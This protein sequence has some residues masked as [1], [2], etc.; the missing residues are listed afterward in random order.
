MAILV[1]SVGDKLMLQYVLNNNL[2][3]RLY[4]N[5]YTPDKTSTISSFTEA[6]ESIPS[7]A[8]AAIPLIFSNWTISTDPVSHLTTA[9][10]PKQIFY[11]NGG[12]VVYGY[13][14]TNSSEV[15]YTER[16]TTAPFTLPT[17]PSGQQN[18]IAITLNIGFN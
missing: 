11:F 2:T 1:P 12:K 13:Y 6:T 9:A 3:L 15:L 17:P 5:N 14:I 10:Y 8:Y 16:F 18:E 7:P 4:S